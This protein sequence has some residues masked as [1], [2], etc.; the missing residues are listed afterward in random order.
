M[1]LKKVIVYFF[2]AD[3]LT[4]YIFNPSAMLETTV[5]ETK[6]K[7]EM[8]PS[9]EPQSK[10]ARTRKRLVQAIRDEVTETGTFTAER[11]AH[12]A[13]SSTPTFYNHFANKEVA[14]V[15][16][17]T[18]L[19]QELVEVVRAKCR[20][21]RLL[22]HGLRKLAQFWV[23]AS[24]Q[25]FRDNAALFRLAQGAMQES[26][27]MRDVFR[28]HEAEIIDQYRQ[29]IERGQA[30]QL[31]RTGEPRAMAELINIT[32]QSWNHPLVLRT[33]EAAPLMKE[34]IDSIV[35]TLEPTPTA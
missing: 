24:V 12:R 1:R 9:I 10:L 20:I 23:A 31:I 26:R 15:A 6:T 35:G 32:A 29:F 18:L 2:Y 13:G 19:M 21:E 33:A 4:I 14:L 8:R 7:G 17:Y 16:A 34:I 11:V 28:T 30:A 22:D 25:F 3:I 27:A 5:S